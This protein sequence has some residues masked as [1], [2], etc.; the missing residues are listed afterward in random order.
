MPGDRDAVGY[1]PARAQAE[2][3]RAIALSRDADAIL[4][5]IVDRACT[6]LGAQ[7]CFVIQVGA[8]ERIRITASRGLISRSRELL[9]RHGREGVSMTALTERRP[10]WSADVLNDPA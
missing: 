9:P 1:G 4:D 10:I 2:V 3:A 6:A 7:R 8:D 5:L